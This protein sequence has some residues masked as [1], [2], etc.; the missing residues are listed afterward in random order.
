MA[1]VELIA[2]LEKAE[3]PSRELDAEI[4]RLV[5]NCDAPPTSFIYEAA[6]INAPA[7][8]AS[9]DAALTLVP[10]V[11]GWT[12]HS[13]HPN[14]KWADSEL[15]CALVYKGRRHRPWA[16]GKT[17]ALALCIAALEARVHL[18]TAERPPDGPEIDRSKVT[19]SQA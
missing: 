3:E 8:T 18:A 1:V 19:D 5:T 9:L 14:H 16:F 12:V 13:S 4:Y 15:P 17:P 10:K 2:K 6:I 11:C 7:Y